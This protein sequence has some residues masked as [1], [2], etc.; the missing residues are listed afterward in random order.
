MTERKGNHATTNS[1]DEAGSGQT[2]KHEPP[3]ATLYEAVH[4]LLSERN[5]STDS[6]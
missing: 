4:S 5:G 3:Y 2:K 6:V 1:G